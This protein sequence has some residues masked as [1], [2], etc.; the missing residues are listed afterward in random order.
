MNL[1]YHDYRRKK[2]TKEAIT[3]YCTRLSRVVIDKIVQ[4]QSNQ[5]AVPILGTSTNKGCACHECRSVDIQ[6]KS[7]TERE[8]GTITWAEDIAVKILS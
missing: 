7:E 4:I 1:P 2:S 6:L 3:M 8:R 5:S